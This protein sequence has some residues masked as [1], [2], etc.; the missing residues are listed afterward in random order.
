MFHKVHFLEWE[1]SLRALA[2]FNMIVIDCVCNPS[3]KHE[4]LDEQYKTGGK[5]KVREM[6]LI[7]NIGT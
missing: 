2:Y 1:G 7:Q 3:L 4:V 6:F 5:E